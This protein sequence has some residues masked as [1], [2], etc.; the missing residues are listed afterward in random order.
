MEVE[1][2]TS[3]EGA[4]GAEQTAAADSGQGSDE[5]AAGASKVGPDG[6]P[7]NTPWRQMEPAEQVLYWQHQSKRHERSAKTV[8][9]DLAAAKAKADQFDALDEASKTDQQREVDRLTKAL[10]D[11]QAERETTQKK[12]GEQL[13]ETR[14][15]AAADAKGMTAASLK[16]LAGDLSRFLGAEGMDPEAVDTFLAALPDKPEG[17]KRSRPDL[18][19]GARTPARVSGLQAG[20]DLFNARHPQKPTPA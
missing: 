18:G 11:A 10:A 12:F 14:L 17:D 16:T 2:G 5:V 9:S 8:Q 3:T 1:G 6:F 13:V 4:A 15:A 7:L 20:A 19:G